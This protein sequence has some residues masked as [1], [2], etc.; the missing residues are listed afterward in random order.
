MP[1]GDTNGKRG[2]SKMI[3]KKLEQTDIYDLVK[4]QFYN[5]RVSIILIKRFMNIILF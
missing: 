1:N 5:F 3:I 4:K 2:A